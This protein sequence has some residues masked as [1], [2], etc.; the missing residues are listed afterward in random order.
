MK[1]VPPGGGGPFLDGSVVT[2]QRLRRK[3]RRI[4]KQNLKA[5]VARRV[6]GERRL[7]TR[8]DLGNVI[9]WMGEMWF[10]TSLDGHLELGRSRAQSIFPLQPPGDAN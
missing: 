2:V 9:Q 3:T 7:A 10:D 6:K 5:V 8:E 4:R 1:N